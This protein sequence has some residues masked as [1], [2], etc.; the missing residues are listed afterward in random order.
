MTDNIEKCPRPLDLVRH[1]VESGQGP[2]ASVEAHVRGCAACKAQLVELEADRKAFLV[3][4]PFS[5]FWEKV[6][7]RRSRRP[8]RIA[9]FFKNIGASGTF[10]AAA[11]M[12]G[13]A[14]LMIVVI[15]RYDRVPEI[16]SKGGVDLRFYVAETKGGEPTPGKSG[17]ALPTETGVQ[18]VYS[19]SKEEA[20]LLLVGVEADGTLSVYFPSNGA[21]S[22][23]IEPGDQKKLPQ[24]LRW[25]PKTAFERFFAIF[26]KE[27]VSADD[28]RKAMEQL[29]ASGKSVEQI[30]K[31]PLPYPQA[32]TIIY[33]KAS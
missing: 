24:A 7:E 1:F 5:S 32:S 8:S 12:A 13:V 9:D 31:L 18:F 21:Q 4:H 27:P 3:S 25:Q 2:S 6:E 16:L 20:Q 22:A 17:M 19:A 15:E 14:A 10:R 26:S 11:A 30:T 29:K 23:P 28:V 33:K